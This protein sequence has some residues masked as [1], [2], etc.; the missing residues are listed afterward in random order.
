MSNQTNSY[1]SAALADTESHTFNFT[2]SGVGCEHATLG[3]LIDIGFE[4]N[5]PGGKGNVTL[6]ITC[7]T[8]HEEFT[9]KSMNG[10]D[11]SE[12]NT[13]IYFPYPIVEIT[14]T[15]ESG[16]GGEV[17]VKASGVLVDFIDVPQTGVTRYLY[18]NQQH[19]LTGTPAKADIT[20]PSGAIGF[21]VTPC[22]VANDTGT[23]EQDGYANNPILA[24]DIDPTGA[25]AFEAA[26]NW[27]DLIGTID[28]SVTIT[29]T[30]NDIW[31]IQFKYDAWN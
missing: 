26:R 12:N 8:Q 7:S 6:D 3:W 27:V 4:Q 9:S 17:I 21:R 13:K 14:A 20:V 22:D 28:E 25:Q 23:I 30:L 16:S 15:C 11:I 5:N 2:N 1:T 24:Y 29:G 10:I 19:T 18:G 31:N